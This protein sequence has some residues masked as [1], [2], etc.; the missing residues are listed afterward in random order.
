MSVEGKAGLG[1]TLIP[2]AEEKAEIEQGIWGNDFLNRSIEIGV[3]GTIS[4][5]SGQTA[6]AGTGVL[7]KE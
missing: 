7:E 6:I 2:E 5:I 3:K 4:L 1:N